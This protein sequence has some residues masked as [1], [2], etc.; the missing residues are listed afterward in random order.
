MAPPGMVY[1]AFLSRL[2]PDVNQDVPRSCFPFM[3]RLSVTS[4]ARI[5]RRLVITYMF[6][7]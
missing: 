4:R 2:T 1:T 3:A 7:S 6:D 5:N